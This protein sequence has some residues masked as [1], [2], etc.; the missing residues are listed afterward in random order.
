MKENWQ[1]PNN[2]MND[3]YKKKIQN[4]KELMTKND[5][6]RNKKK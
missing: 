5:Y 3:G 6:K 2:P 4:V 1:Q